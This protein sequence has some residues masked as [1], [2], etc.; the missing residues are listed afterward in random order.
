MAIYFAIPG[1]AAPGIGE[2]SSEDGFPAAAMLAPNFGKDLEGHESKPDF[3]NG[4]SIENGHFNRN[5]Q[6]WCFSFI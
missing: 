4:Q 3:N 1:K 6:Q 5:S 2:L